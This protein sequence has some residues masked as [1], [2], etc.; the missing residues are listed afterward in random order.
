MKIAPK[1][2]ILSKVNPVMLKN[3]L[4]LEINIVNSVSSGG[5]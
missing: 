3:Y 4:L 2:F 5:K 1:T